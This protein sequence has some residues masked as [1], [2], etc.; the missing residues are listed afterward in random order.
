MTR[1]AR[2]LETLFLAMFA[3]VPL[4][5]TL[6]IGKLPLFLFH[7]AMTGIALRVAAGKGPELIPARLMRWMAIAYVPFYLVDWLVLSHSAIAASTHL[8]LFIAVYQPIEAMKRENQ[9]QRI[10][11]AALIFVASIATSTHITIVLFV[12]AFAFLIFRQLMSIS[13]LETARTLEREYAEAPSARAALFYVCG[14]LVIGAALFPFLPRVRNPFVQGVTGGLPGATTALSETIDFREPRVTALDSTIIARIW[15]DYS[16]RPFF[17]PIRLRGNIYDDYRNGQWQQRARGIR[18]LPLRDDGFF[19][20]RR[21]GIDGSAAVQ[22]KAEAGKLYLPV[23]TYNIDG[24]TSLYEGPARDTYYTYNRGLLNFNVR[25]ALRAEPLR[26]IRVV[27]I[28]YPVTPEVAKLARE[29]VG[30]ETSP[31]RQAR[32][33]EQWMLTNFRYVPNPST[34]PAM[35]IERFLLRDR[36]GHCEYFAAGMAVMLTALDV[37]ARIAGGYHGGRFNP[38]MGYFTVRRDDAHAWTE[39]W[40]GTRWLTFDATPPALRPGTESG[41]MMGAYASALSDSI[42]YFWDRYIL[43]FGLSD[44]I[45]FFTDVIDWTRERVASLS[46]GARSFRDRTF[47]MLLSLVIAIGAA[48]IVL[49]RRR[50]TLFDLIAARLAARGVTVAPSATVEEA[51]AELRTRDP[52]FANAIAPAIAMYEEET[53]SGRGDPMRRRTLRRMLAQLS[54]PAT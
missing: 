1:K 27:P 31:E 41:S 34:P 19:I 14:A 43:T 39:V 6:A 54:N 46:A 49:S 23:G 32:L 7:A 33:I 50:R 3:A 2:E 29:V 44:Q 37:P 51:L 36:L 22:M 18:P 26:S 40:N 15:I 42:N 25:M 48:A 17:I 12:L 35:S 52:Q 11:T 24:L 53:F 30:A 45:S 47:V 28:D 16:R 20:G 21:D 9:A 10:L 5:L 13:H 8:V 38:L 4:Y